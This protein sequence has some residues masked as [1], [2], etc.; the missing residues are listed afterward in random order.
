MTVLLWSGPQTSQGHEDKNLAARGPRN[1]VR[2][3]DLGTNSLGQS[4]AGGGPFQN[5]KVRFEKE[6]RGSQRQASISLE[7]GP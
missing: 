1:R 5:W 6:S 4:L 2:R 3:A 7:G